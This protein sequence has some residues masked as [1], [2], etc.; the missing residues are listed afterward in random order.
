MEAEWEE[1]FASQ[2]PKDLLVLAFTR[3][4]GD[5]RALQGDRGC[6]KALGNINARVLVMP[7]STDQLSLVETPRSWYSCNS[8]SGLTYTVYCSRR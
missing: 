8:S 5:I 3:H 2:E 1:A 6:L 4:A 7:A